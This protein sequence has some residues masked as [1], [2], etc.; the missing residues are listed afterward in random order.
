MFI[1]HSFFEILRFAQY[2]TNFPAACHSEAKL[3]GAK[4]SLAD[5]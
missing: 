4:E 5:F 2:D 3:S 1:H